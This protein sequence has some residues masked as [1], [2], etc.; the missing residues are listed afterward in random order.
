MAFIGPAWRRCVNRFDQVN[1]FIDESAKAIGPGVL[2]S[3]RV[4]L[5]ESWVLLLYSA[6]Q[7]SIDEI[8]RAC[9]EFL[10]WKYRFPSDLPKETFYLHQQS[11]LDSIRRSSERESGREDVRD[12]LRLMYSREWAKH[13]EMLKLENNVW[14]TVLRNWLRRLGVLDGELRWMLDPVRGGSETYESRMSALVQERNPIA[15]GQPVGTILTAA[16]M[17]DWLIDCRIFVERCCMS[18]ALALASVHEPRL[19]RL[20]LTDPKVR[21]GNH[22]IALRQLAHSVSVSDHILLASGG[23]RKKVVRVDS[24]M[25]NGQSYNTLPPGSERVSIGLSGEHHGYGAYLVP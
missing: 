1:D 24:I 5:Y 3:F 20:G 23:D 17:Q 18:V 16:V 14:P 13:S 7:Y 8:G 4:N 22:T 9:M 21:L 25:S 2:P 6:C 11:T 12:R 10:G 19:L 15:H